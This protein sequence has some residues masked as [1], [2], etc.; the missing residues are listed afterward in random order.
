M[1]T[2]QSLH[3]FLY[4]TDLESNLQHIILE[5]ARASKYTAHAIKTEEAHQSGKQNIQGEEQLALDERCDD[6]FCSLLSESD[7]VCIFASEEQDTAKKI[8]KNGEYAVAFDPLDGSSLLDTNGCVGSI[9]GIWKSKQFE[10]L[11]G[12]DLLSAGYIQYGPRTTLILSVLGKTHE[13][14]LSDI[15]EYH[16]SKSNISIA[17]DAKNF[18]IGNIR[19]VA[20]RK[21]YESVLQYCIHSG[22]TLRYAG[23]MV[24]DIN[25]ILSKKSG[26]FTYPSHSKYPKGKLRLLYECIPMAFIMINAGGKAIDEHGNN[27]L[28]LP[29][30][31]IHERRSILLGSTNDVNHIKNLLH[32]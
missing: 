16:I 12:R 9:F 11:Y 17:D 22:K 29:I 6:I 26:V 14:T 2:N 5:I 13:F 27:I 28:D 19:A 7:K 30:Q 23:G 8:H 25:T 15:G 1:N 10:G 4:Q 20:E 24:P 32:S 3:D 31:N 21:E 18:A